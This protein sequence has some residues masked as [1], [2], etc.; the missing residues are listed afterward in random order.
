MQTADLIK[1]E[2]LKYPVAVRPET[3][4]EA[5]AN[6]ILKYN[7][8][9]LCRDPYA[10]PA[11]KDFDPKFII[12]GGA[13]IGTA[14]IFFANR[15]PNAEILAIEPELG[16]IEMMIYNLQYY[17][18][19]KILHAALWNRETELAIDDPYHS[20]NGFMMREISEHKD[21]ELTQTVTIEKIFRESGFDYMDILKLDVEGS[22]KEIFSDRSNYQSWLPYVKVLIIEL[23]D[24]MKR[25]CS[26]NFFR[27]VSWYKYFFMQSGGNL[28]FIREDLL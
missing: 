26:Y 2:S 10:P 5:T 14:S 18:Q 4:D 24:R 25:N 22:E 21:R 15:Y 16:N 28:I 1:F 9:E 11:I 3:S 7:V 12:D 13:N 17:P 19:V 23:H 6:E 20:F 27:A 8:Y